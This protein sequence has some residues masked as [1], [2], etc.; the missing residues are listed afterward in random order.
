MVTFQVGVK[1]EDAKTR[2]YDKMY[3][4]YDLRPYN[5]NDVAIRSIDPEDL[6][7]V[8]YAITYSGLTENLSLKE[9]GQYLQ[10][11]AK[12]LRESIKTIP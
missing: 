3:A 4:N 6:P 2:L 12:T 9:Q 1:Q 11:I 10:N 5:I 7:Q 8:T